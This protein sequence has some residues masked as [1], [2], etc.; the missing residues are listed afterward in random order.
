M[1]LLGRCF[2]RMKRA[3][4]HLLDRLLLRGVKIAIPNL[5]IESIGSL[6]SDTRTNMQDIL[7]A[8]RL[9]IKL[10]PDNDI[11]ASWVKASE[12]HEFARVRELCQSSQSPDIGA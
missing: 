9:L 5:L 4:V 2:Q 8:T 12:N 10:A 1:A 11:A 3:V 6:A 7:V